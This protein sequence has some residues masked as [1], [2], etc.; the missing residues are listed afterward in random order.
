NPIEYEGTFPLP[1][2]QLDRFMLNIRMGYPDAD[3]EV[4]IL[5]RQ[6]RENPVDTLGQ[7]LSAD[8]LMRAFTIVR[9][10][11][12][13][14][15]IRRYIVELVAATRN[16]DQVYLGA[17]PRGS[18]ALFHGAQAMAAL[19]GRASAWVDDVKALV[20]PVLAHRIII[21]P[22]ARVR[23]VTSS[24]ILDDVLGRVRVPAGP[25]SLNGHR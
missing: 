24:A 12:V 23:G 10:V 3:E 22:A 15:E 20:K 6:Q 4:L 11:E 13:K 14:Q 9:E 1:E 5:G 18:L 8:D 16:H 25:A 19:D 7:V 17:S 21:A 2:A